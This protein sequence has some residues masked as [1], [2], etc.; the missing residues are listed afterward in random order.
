[1]ALVA[2]SGARPAKCQ[3]AFPSLTQ[4]P[5]HSAYAAS[6][7]T[8]QDA[9]LNT[10]ATVSL[11]LDWPQYPAAFSSALLV[12]S[13][14]HHR[15]VVCRI[16]W[17]ACTHPSLSPLRTTNHMS[18]PYSSV[19]QL[20]FCQHTMVTG[21]YSGM[22][23]S[24]CWQAPVA[25]LMQART[26]SGW[27]MYVPVGGGD[28]G[29]GGGVDPQA[30]TP[31]RIVRT[32]AAGWDE[33]GIAQRNEELVDAVLAMA[34]PGR[35]SGTDPRRGPC[36][37]RLHRAAPPGPSRGDPRRGHPA[38]HGS[39]AARGDRHRARRRPRGDRRPLV[40]QPL[41]SRSH[42]LGRPQ[43]GY[44]FWRLEDGRRLEDVRADFRAGAEAEAGD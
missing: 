29:G 8:V 42:L 28:G 9:G 22:V 39:A 11:A 21:V 43:N 32:A 27:L 26:P 5:D 44:T 17:L 23:R 31:G 41:R 6:P 10:A 7:G 2:V 16:T 19:T 1:M 14:P 3:A 34:G 24:T 30:G 36:T 20:P 33:G 12:M 25:R 37:G 38:R 35:T 13:L 15:T 40:R 4:S 18:V